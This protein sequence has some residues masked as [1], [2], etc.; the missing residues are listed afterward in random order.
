MV[1]DPS[2]PTLTV[3]ERFERLE[4]GVT[5]TAQLLR[6]VAAEMQRQTQ[7]AAETSLIINAVL[8]VL[9]DAISEIHPEMDTVAF[10]KRLEA[11]HAKLVDEVNKGLAAAREEES[12]PAQGPLDDIQV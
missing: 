4:K 11:E 9:Q 10:G 2:T 5:H 3:D 1:N 6:H 8:N 7:Y 12:T